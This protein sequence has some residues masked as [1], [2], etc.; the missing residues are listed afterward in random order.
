[1]PMR[2]R[3]MSEEIHHEP[4]CYWYELAVGDHA[5]VKIRHLEDGVDI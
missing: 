3:G 4:G 2:T 5:L 1:M